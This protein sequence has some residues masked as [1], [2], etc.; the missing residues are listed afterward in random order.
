MARS[1]TEI[2]A[3]MTAVF[4]ANETLATSYG[5]SIGASFESEFSLLSL[6]NILF[7][8][9]AFA[10]FL[11]ELIFDQHSA[12]VDQKLL[13]QKSGRA[14][15]YRTMALR[16]QYGF[17]LLPDSDLFDNSNAT[18]DQVEA[19]KIIKY[20]A[21][22]ESDSESR[23]I[24]K[25]AGETNNELAPIQAQQR[26]A[27]DAYLNEIRFAGVK[28]TVINY[29]PDRLYLSLRIYRDPLVL[30]DNGQ[31]ILTG[32]KPVEIAINEFMKELPFNGELIIQSLVDKLQQV[33]GVRIAHVL[34]VETSW[35]DPAID[36][37]GAPEQVDV[38]RIAVSG[39]YKVVNFDN[40][41]YVA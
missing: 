21:V 41:E 38:K 2:K 19:S 12:E 27:F 5:F 18:D 22:E 13:N 31:S 32:E 17:D 3:E 33:P 15:W 6:E 40:I 24:L 29:E 36:D 37:Y 26:E 34:N 14:T 9:V 20:S 1:K 23:L 16:F 4:M 39:Y 28:I 30:D 8:I 35:I 10:F 11:H 25:I 7:E